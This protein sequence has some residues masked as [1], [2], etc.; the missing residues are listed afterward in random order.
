MVNNEILGGLKLALSKGESL[1]LAMMSFYNAGYKK[2]EIEEAARIAQQE[3]IK[4]QEIQQEPKKSSKF[5][6]ANK[7]IKPRKS[8]KVSEYGESPKVQEKEVKSENNLKQKNNKKEK[9]IKKSSKKVSEYT[10]LH[11]PKGKIMLIILI[12]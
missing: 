3:N 11:K 4:P 7:I 8:S 5:S 1:K 9:L 6:S 10:Q 12:A 2:E